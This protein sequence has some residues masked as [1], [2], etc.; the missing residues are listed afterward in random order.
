[1]AATL[2]NSDPK[3]PPGPVSYMG[4]KIHARKKPGFPFYRASVYSESMDMA[5]VRIERDDECLTRDQIIDVAK[6]EIE[7]GQ[8]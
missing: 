1:M 8:L 6:W 3:Y 2:D 7:S 4:F 5:E